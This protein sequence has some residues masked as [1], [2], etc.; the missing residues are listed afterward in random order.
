MEQS[1]LGNISGQNINY[2]TNVKVS[3]NN[4]L[5]QT[6]QLEEIE[7]PENILKHLKVGQTLSGQITDIRG[8][9]L[10]ISVN[11]QNILAQLADAFT[12]TIGQEATFIV[13]ENNGTQLL[14]K[15]ADGMLLQ[16]T[17][18]IMMEQ[19]LEAAGFPVTEKNLELVKNLILNQQPIDKQTLLQYMKTMFR[20]PDTNINTLIALQKNNLPVTAEN[21]QNLEN[22]QTY[23]SEFTQEM[24]NLSKNIGDFIGELAANQGEEKVTQFL[25]K[26]WDTFE[27]PQTLQTQQEIKPESGL[28]QK[29][30]NPLQL[31]EQNELIKLIGQDDITELIQNKESSPEKILNHLKNIIENKNIASEDIVKLVQ[32]D[33]FQKLLEKT[34]ENRM[35]LQ[36]EDLQKEG[37]IKEYYRKTGEKTEKLQRMLLEFGGRESSSMKTVTNMSENLKMM[38]AVNEFLNYVQLPLKLINQ[39]TKGDLYVYTKKKNLG[40]NKE[41][42]TAMLHL[43]MEYLGAIDVF[44][45]MKEK[46]VST[47]FILETEELLDFIEEH[48]ELLNKRLEEKG[49]SVSSSVKKKEL[50]KEELEKDITSQI[51]RFEAEEEITGEWERKRFSFDMRI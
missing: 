48:I 42:L 45:K 30:E 46:K 1:N 24:E 12:F 38:N 20:F 39:N 8:N 25:T 17:G 44:V 47:N 16:N 21:I 40:K 36:P 26:L 41:E 32:S 18:N 29:P 2:N 14:L 33:G 34:I 50:E 28:E 35:L 13:K 22:Y 11:N 10:Q 19:A 7:N 51:Q 23:E 27:L 49:Y 43:D 3:Q 31:Q 6:A 5:S 37:A 4:S 9:I 15:P